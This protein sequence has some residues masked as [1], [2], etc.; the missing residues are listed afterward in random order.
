[1]ESSGYLDPFIKFN[2]NLQNS[3][4]Y[5]KAT[6]ARIATYRPF[7]NTAAIMYG[8]PPR[9]I[10][11][12][13]MTESSFNKNARSSV[14]AQGLMQLMP[15]TAKAMGVT[16]PFDARQNILGGT[17]YLR[18]LI[19]SYEGN[20]EN[21][22]MAYNWGPDNVNSYLKKVANNE[23]NIFIPRETQ[24][25][26]SKIHRLYYPYSPKETRNLGSLDNTVDDTLIDKLSQ[27]H[28]TTFQNMS[29]TMGSFLD[30]TPAQ[31]KTEEEPT[32]EPVTPS[33]FFATNIGE[34][35]LPFFDRQGSRQ[36]AYAETPEEYDLLSEWSDKY[37]E[38]QR[39]LLVGATPMINSLNKSLDEN[40]YLKWPDYYDTMFR[41]LLEKINFGEES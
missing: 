24:A 16:D 41:K 30:H 1:M 40:P 35:G 29:D 34:S 19:D 14:G 6:L 2:K 8:L 23:K 13:I 9:L 22:L 5:D 36:T 28:Q 10:T 37:N 7:I 4:A 11:A 21:A 32:L 27:M 3:T 26:L 25:F 17:K 39:G 31:T 15:A 33:N 38:E 18:Y 20:V 12:L